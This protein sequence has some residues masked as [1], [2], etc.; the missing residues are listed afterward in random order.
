MQR[1]GDGMSAG[2]FAG[3]R[4]L[5]NSAKNK[6]TFTAYIVEKPTE[7]QI[8]SEGTPNMSRNCLPESAEEGC[9]V[10]NNKRKLSDFESDSETSTSSDESWSPCESDSPTEVAGDVVRTRSRSGLAAVQEADPAVLQQAD[11]EVNQESD[12]STSTEESSEESSDDE[13]EE[14]DES[15][16]NDDEYSDDDS[17]VTSSDEGSRHSVE[18]GKSE[19]A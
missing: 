18:E 9:V 7:R 14:E 12:F 2:P 16:T 11:A 17:F 6:L 15:D 1:I 13:E 19:I 8:M 10:A 3:F 5:L 4:L